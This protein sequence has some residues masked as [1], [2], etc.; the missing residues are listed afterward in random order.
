MH[1]L[2]SAKSSPRLSRCFRQVE[3]SHFL[4]DRSS[5]PALAALPKSSLTATQLPAQRGR[6]RTAVAPPLPSLTAA[7]LVAA[8][9][10]S[11]RSRGCTAAAPPLTAASSC[12]GEGRAPRSPRP[13]SLPCRSRR[14][15]AALVTAGLGQIGRRWPE[16][17]DL[18]GGAR[19][20]VVSV[21][22]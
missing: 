15:G 1:D 14:R 22:G 10:L 18:T 9:Q 20:R 21:A 7:V 11:Q 3:N 16:K 13:C 2:K 4:S 8:Q 17:K 19:G 6:G 5:S 12:R